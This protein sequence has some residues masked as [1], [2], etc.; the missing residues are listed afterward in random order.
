MFDGYIN[1]AAPRYTVSCIH[2][3]VYKNGYFLGS[4][5]GININIKALGFVMRIEFNY[6][7]DPPQYMASISVILRLWALISFCVPARKSLCQYVLRLSLEI[8]YIM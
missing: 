2:S 5:H 4:C 6:L 7:T 1:R 8:Q 3:L